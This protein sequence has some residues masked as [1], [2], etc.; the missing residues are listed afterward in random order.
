[1]VLTV[2][3][4]PQ[5]VLSLSSVLQDAQDSSWARGLAV[6]D[7]VAFCDGET[8]APEIE[9]SCTPSTDGKMRVRL[10]RPSEQLKQ[11]DAQWP[12]DS[13][14]SL[15]FMDDVNDAFS[16]LP[17]APKRMRIALASATLNA[18]GADLEV[19]IR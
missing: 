1:M 12:F 18:D 6:G 9:V 14:S 7:S 3:A 11:E 5:A 13:P 8:G 4:L 2:F 17:K 19:E 10:H 16:L 15:G